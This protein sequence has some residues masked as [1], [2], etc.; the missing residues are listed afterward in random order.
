MEKNTVVFGSRTFY[1]PHVLTLASFTRVSW[2]SNEIN[3]EKVFYKFYKELLTDIIIPMSLFTILFNS[4]CF[5]KYNERGYKPSNH[6]QWFLIYPFILFVNK[7]LLMF[8][9]EQSNCASHGVRGEYK[10][11]STLRNFHVILFFFSPFTLNHPVY[12]LIILCFCTWD[13]MG[14]RKK[15]SRWHWRGFICVINSLVQCEPQELYL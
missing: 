9:Y 5:H 1:F 4:N 6:S 2:G 12:Q 11:I 14:W 8:C 10:D 7:Y 15:L 3:Y 13:R